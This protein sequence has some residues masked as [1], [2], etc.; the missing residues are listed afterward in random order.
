MRSALFYI[1]CL[2][3]SLIPIPHGLA[4][5][6]GVF[7]SSKFDEALWGAPK[8][9][10]SDGVPDT[11]DAFPFDPTETADSDSDSVGDN[12]DAFPN[13]SRE[14]LDTDSDG[15]GNNAD[16]D[17]DGDGL[18][19]QTEIAKGTDPLKADTDGDG[20]DDRDDVFPLD[21]EEQSDLDADG[22]GD[23]A[24]LDDDADGLLDEWD[25]NPTVSNR[26]DLALYAYVS[27]KKTFDEAVEYAEG[28]GAHLVT[29][30]SADE[31]QLI[32]ALTRSQLTDDLL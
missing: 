28:L 19:D 14:T 23:N 1:G 4:A 27:E 9:S 13:D 7:D 22:L 21:A 18:S 11:S 5:D 15:V 26:N 12:S 20:A 6:V 8:D 25:P 30:N 17:D 31:N 3:V 10:D 32:Y 2:L 16:D 29:I 24:D